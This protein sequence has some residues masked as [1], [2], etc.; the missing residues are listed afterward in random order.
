M[1]SKI[2]NIIYPPKCMFCGEKLNNNDKYYCKKCYYKLPFIEEKR[3]LICGREIFGDRKL[4]LE[5]T[6]HRRHV[7]VVYPAFL[8]SGNIK[9]ALLKYKFAGK[10]YYHKPFAELIYE[11]IKDS[12]SDVDCIVYP[13]I[14][15]KTFYKR[16]FNQCELIAKIL[17]EKFDIKLLK[18]AIY[19]TREN[20]KQSL[21]SR[22]QRY[23]NVKGVFAVNDSFSEYL[24]GK[25][26]LLIDDVMTTGATI[27]ECSKMLKKKGVKTVKSA[28]LCITG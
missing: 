5:C 16:G 10:M 6:R 9:E 15:I 26:V 18:K 4:C 17:S 11:N 22:E 7:D 19:K 28:T 20:E 25:T 2:L 14:N 1:F 27:D 12:I 23:K 8:Y 21:M 13:P 3:C 24:K